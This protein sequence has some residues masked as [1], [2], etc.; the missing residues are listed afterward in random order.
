V[1]EDQQ[2]LFIV[3]LD[4]K[5][6]APEYRDTLRIMDI[7]SDARET[8]MYL[9]VDAELFVPGFP[10]S[11]TRIDPGAK[12]VYPKPTG[13]SGWYMGP[14]A[15]EEGCH[16]LRLEENLEIAPSVDGFSGSP[17]FYMPVIEGL[18]YWA[19]VGMLIRASTKRGSF[20]GL[21]VIVRGLNNIIE[22]NPSG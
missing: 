9:P 13:L 18:K 6:M 2:D 4:E 3:E 21:P 16:D 1:D 11:R 12:V 20:I 8:P 17:V 7:P 14:S 5:G 15:T 10:K 19:L 22:Q